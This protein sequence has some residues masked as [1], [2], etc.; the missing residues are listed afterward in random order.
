MSR[1]VP[2]FEG[3][4]DLNTSTGVLDWFDGLWALPRRLTDGC[5]AKQPADK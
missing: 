2:F 4:E 3:L 5:S 1:L